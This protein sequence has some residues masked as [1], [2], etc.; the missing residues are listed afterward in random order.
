M[1]FIM[2]TTI[3]RI[4]ISLLSVLLLASCMDL[5]EMSL[6]MTDYQMPE[7]SASDAVDLS[8][9]GTANSYI[10]SKA[11]AYRI[12][13]VK[14]NSSESVGPVASATV[15]WESFGTDEKPERGELIKAVMYKDNSIYFFT[16]DQFREG[17]AVIAAKD[18]SGCILWSWHI[19]MTDTPVEQVYYDNAGTMMDRNLGATS[20]APGDVG[21]LGLLYQWGRKDPFLGSSSISSSTEAKSTITWPSA[22]SSSSSTGTIDFAVSHPTTFIS[23]N[24]SNNDWYH[25]S[26][27]GTDDTRWQSEKTIYDPCP[28]GWRVPDGGNDGVWSKAG[29]YSIAYDNADEGI[30][31][32]VSF[33]I[34]TW[35]PAS[36]YRDLDGGALDAVGRYG[37]YWSVT[38]DLVNAYSLGLSED[39]DVNPSK[40]NGR[41][42]GLGVRCFKEGS[43]SDGSSSSGTVEI[44]PSSAVSLSDNGTANSYIVS[45]S[46]TY[47]IPAVKGNTLES[48]G[49]VAS[50]EV[51]W[52]SFGTSVAPKQGNLVAAAIYEGGNIYFKTATAFREGNAVIA[53]KD[54]S[55]KILW[56][57]HIWMT[58]KPQVQAYNNGAG[59]VMDRNL[60]ATSATAGDVGALGLLYQWGRKDPFLG[61]ASI[62]ESQLAQSTLAWPSA[63]ASNSTS[64]TVDYVTAH[65]TTFVKGASAI[66][67]DWHY[68]LRDDGLWAAEKTIYDPCPAGW[69]VPDGGESGLWSTAGF[70]SS[71]YEAAN[72]GIHFDISSPSTT[73]YPAAGS[74]SY[75][76]AELTSVGNYGYYWSITPYTSYACYLYFFSNGSVNPA[77]DNYRSYAF[78]VRCVEDM[79]QDDGNP[80]VW[81]HSLSAIGAAAGRAGVAVAGDKVY[82][83]AAG[84]LWAADAATGE[85]AQ[86]MALPKG[87]IAGGVHVDDAGN[88][89][90]SGEDRAPGAG[91][92]Q[93]FKVAADGSYTALVDYDSANYSCTE[94]GNFRVKGDVNGDAL[95]M[96]YICDGTGHYAAWEVK[97]GVVAEAPVYG[98]LHDGS[99]DASTG[100]VAPAGATLADGFFAITY[101]STYNLNYFNGEAWSEIYVTGSIWME[102]YNCISTTEVNGKKYLAMTAS[103]HFDYDYTDIIVLD[104]T[105]VTAVAE[106]FKIQMNFHTVNAAGLTYS[107]IFIKGE[108]GKLAA[109]VID[110]WMDTVEKYLFYLL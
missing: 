34:T 21:A 10:V 58:D 16:G 25:T 32:S 65:P 3:Y 99:W 108:D 64:G 66:S 15:L 100:V 51:L 55:G 11:G 87:F 42:R 78:S 39:G 53:A 96:A 4:T 60:G 82:F 101:G 19:W 92:L 26:S 91:M 52:E 7:V 79:N 89:M 22:V 28:V 54:A 74:L 33:P 102:N 107:D 85:N 29:F 63:V 80:I 5:N 83:T 98:D 43:G 86:K 36:G 38:S 57:W 20:A 69:R 62:S 24:G 35:Y 12:S 9:S 72:K 17:N 40:T 44:N 56:S 70:T 23:Y 47:S 76:S 6:V 81:S 14:G 37:Y 27:Y 103:C 97:G 1:K 45:S 90:V 110:P 13:S 94:M 61:S 68:A 46:G 77:N 95:I 109:Y 67:Y 106:V 73:W 8:A 105:D 75:D 59:N 93:L 31:F 48:V 30:S 41:A 71:T 18:D 50:V 104:V 88:L 84:E 49:S 2:K